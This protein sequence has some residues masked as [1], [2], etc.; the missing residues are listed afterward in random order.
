MIAKCPNPSTAGDC[1]PITIFSCVYR[2]WCSARATTL[3]PW[4]ISIMPAAM[5][6]FI[7]GRHLE[8]FLYQ[9]ALDIEAA[10]QGLTG[11]LVGMSLD[12]TK[13]FN[14][15]PRAAAFAI[16]AQLGMPPWLIQSWRNNLHRLTRRAKVAGTMSRA[17]HSCTGFPEGCPLS[18]IAMLAIGAAWH[19]VTCLPTHNLKVDSFADNF[20]LCCSAVEELVPGLELGVQFLG[21]LDLHINPSK[22]VIWSTDP[23]IR[24]SLDQF[25]FS[26]GK[27]THVRDVR[28]LGGHFCFTYAT[29]NRTVQKRLAE[30][31]SS[32]ERICQQ[33]GPFRVKLGL[34]K[35]AAHPRA[36]WGM[37]ITRLGQNR[38]GKYITATKKALGQGRAGAN[39]YIALAVLQEESTHPAFLIHYHRI[40][41]F[42]LWLQRPPPQ[43]PDLGQLWTAQLVRPLDGPVSLFA[44]SLEA[45]DLDLDP[46]MQ[47]IAPEGSFD[48]RHSPWRLIQDLLTRGFHREQGTFLASRKILGQART[49]DA[50]IL[51]KVLRRFPEDEQG[52]L[53]TAATGARY[54]NAEIAQYNPNWAPE[55][56]LCGQQDTREHRF[57]SCSATSGIRATRPSILDQWIELPEPLRENLLPSESQTRSAFLGCLSHTPQPFLSRRHDNS[58]SVWFTDASGHH[59]ASRYSLVAYAGVCVDPQTGEERYS[60]QQILDGPLQS[61]D[62]GEL[63]AILCVLELTWHA[64]VYTDSQYAAGIIHD[65]QTGGLSDHFA[66]RPNSDL[67]R[68]VYNALHGRP[69]AVFGVSWVK[70]HR[71]IATA[72]SGHDAFLIRGNDTADRAANEAHELWEPNIKQLATRGIAED[73]RMI[74]TLTELAQLHVQVARVFA[75]KKGTEAPSSSTLTAVLGNTPS[76]S[77]QLAGEAYV[78][79]SEVP[80]FETVFPADF[81]W[82]FCNF[83]ATLRWK[84]QPAQAGSGTPIILIGLLFYERTGRGLPVR[85]KNT[86]HWRG[87][88][89][90]SIRRQANALLVIFR[91]LSRTIGREVVPGFNSC[92]KKVRPLH[93]FVDDIKW[94][95]IPYFLGDAEFNVATTLAQGLFARDTAWTQKGLPDRVRPL[96][97]FHTPSQRPS[98]CDGCI[99]LAKWQSQP[100]MPARRNSVLERLRGEAR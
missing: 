71:N 7:A 50:P 87:D 10:Q 93:P 81:I 59:P 58:H 94:M 88:L 68:N 77:E 39:P 15:I 38:L 56:A 65:L 66:R 72:V 73:A 33:G 23:A 89:T 26:L 53:R 3:Q 25:T 83:L 44:E 32:L 54:A 90:Q 78:D 6:G 52:L 29:R 79:C 13:A 30:A 100:A 34:V 98:N 64:T 49:V 24:R 9:L 12:I 11:P 63:T 70:A 42:W 41:Q 74:Q 76:T 22:C 84:R 69:A 96:P 48:L 95:I 37:N 45:C 36:L 82:Y 60:F 86:W 47:I 43:E 16:L 31:T 8:D 28:E 67:V 14:Y 99:A 35:R 20:N 19:Q 5:R 40:R 17:V 2:A 92:F 62:R 27:P 1:R 21:A 18:P 85:D 55:C 4:L 97:P 57:L 75:T 51:R 91:L 61:V 80:G 46:D